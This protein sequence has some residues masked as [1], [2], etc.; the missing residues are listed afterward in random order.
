VLDPDNKWRDYW[1]AKPEEIVRSLH[2]HP[3]VGTAPII[4]AYVYDY[5]ANTEFASATR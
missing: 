4:A 1:I 5:H 2:L 3:H